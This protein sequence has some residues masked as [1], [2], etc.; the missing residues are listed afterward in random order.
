[1]VER[2][3]IAVGLRNFGTVFRSFYWKH[4]W[5]SKKTADRKVYECAMHA[6][7]LEVALLTADNILG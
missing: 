4:V 1:M 2:P 6:P 5:E 3:K 7:V